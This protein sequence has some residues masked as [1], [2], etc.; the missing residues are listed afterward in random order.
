[1]RD[2][3][4]EGWEEISEIGQRRWDEPFPIHVDASPS[5]REVIERLDD[6]LAETD[7]NPRPVLNEVGIPLGG[8]LAIGRIQVVLAPRAIHGGFLQPT[9][10]VPVVVP[11]SDRVIAYLITLPGEDDYLFR[12]HKGTLWHYHYLNSAEVRS[13]VILCW[14]TRQT[15]NES[16]HPVKAA[17]ALDANADAESRRSRWSSGPGRVIGRGGGGTRRRYVDATGCRSDHG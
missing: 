13:D 3:L 14:D 9:L 4:W 7:F 8:G 17:A 6:V 5:L 16:I 12:E 1:M 15:I 11:A 10:N 2:V